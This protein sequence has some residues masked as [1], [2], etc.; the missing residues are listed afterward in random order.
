M[1]VRVAVIQTDPR[2]GEVEANIRE[3]LAIAESAG[4]DIL[5][6]PELCNTGYNFSSKQEVEKLAE[7][8]DGPTYGAFAMFAE[9]ASCHVVYG[10]AEKSGRRYY[11]SAAL[12]GPNGLIGLYRKVHLFNRELLFFSP[13]DLGFPVFRLPFGIVGI[14]ICFDWIYPEAARTLALK[15]AQLVAHPSNLVMPYCPDAMV[16]RCLEN[17]VFA[18]T[19]DRVGT[20]NRGGVQFEYRGMSEIVSPKGEILRRLGEREHGVA[21]ADVELSEANVKKVNEYNDLL[22]DRRPET[23]LTSG[24]VRRTTRARARRRRKHG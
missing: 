9:K 7:P 17:R 11:N 24:P 1:S 13:G 18:A 20:E 21:A 22:K 6:F 16:T 12:V 3:A 23:Y 19:A 10:F 2:F 8:I 14:M 5:V 15:G 4:A